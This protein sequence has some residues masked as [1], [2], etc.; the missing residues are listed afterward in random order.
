MN[1]GLKYSEYSKSLRYFKK[2]VI[3]FSFTF[4]NEFR[5]RFFFFKTNLFLGEGE[6]ERKRE[7]AKRGAEGEPE[8]TSQ[9]DS[10]ATMKLDTGINPM[11]Q[12]HDPNPNQ[13]SV[14]QPTVPPRYSELIPEVIF[15]RTLR[16]KYDQARKL[17]IF[18]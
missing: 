4:T 12:D 9:A 10:P 7:Q 5:F 15:I 17:G 18:L 16:K 8:R 11:T 13:A 6:R 14:A 3:L 1:Y 2:W